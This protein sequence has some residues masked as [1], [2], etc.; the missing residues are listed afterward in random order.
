VRAYFEGGPDNP[1][2]PVLFEQTVYGEAAPSAA[3]LNLCGRLWQQ[4]DGAGRAVND[5]YDFKGNV[6][7]SSRRL[8]TEYRTTPDW[9]V[10]PTGKLEAEEFTSRSWFDALN[11]PIQVVP[12]HS[13]QTTTSVLRPIYNVAG[14][15]DSEYAWLERAAEPGEG[16]LL[17][18][19]TAT[20]RPIV[21]VVY[22]ARGQR[23]SISYGN[24]V[25][26]RYAYDDRTFRLLGLRTTRPGGRNGMS[27]SLFRDATVVQD[28]SYVYDAAGNITRIEDAALREIIFGGQVVRPV[29]EYTYDALYRLIEATGREHIAQ[30]TYDPLRQN[31][32]DYPFIGPGPAVTDP[33]AFRTYTERYLY[34]DVGNIT[35]LQHRAAGGDWTR[36]YR[37]AAGSNRL[38]STS[39]PGDPD[40]GPY[41]ATYGHNAHGDLV[42]AWNLERLDWDLKGQ[43]SA[44]AVQR[45]TIGGT[46]PETTYYAYDASGRRFR[47]ITEP[48]T[49]GGAAAS[50]LY[51]RI[52]VGDFELYR[53]Y[54]AGGDVEREFLRLGDDRQTVAIV[55]TP[56]RQLPSPNPSPRVFRYQIADHLGS[57]G[58][59][60]DE[61]AALISHEEY[62]PYGTTAYRS[63][64]ASHEVQARRYR[65]SGLERDE[66]T[67]L[68]Y[69]GARY[70]SPW[71]GRWISCDP[72]A[73]V[74]DSNLYAYV[75]AN[76][77]VYVDPTGTQH[78]VAQQ[79]RPAVPTKAQAQAWLAKQDPDAGLTPEAREAR[80]FWAG[81]RIVNAI[82]DAIETGVRGI[83][84]GLRWSL[85][86]VDPTGLVEARIDQVDR[87]VGWGDTGQGETGRAL[88]GALGLVAGPEKVLT[89]AESKAASGLRAM[90]GGGELGK[91]VTRMTA[92]EEALRAAASTEATVKAGSEVKA[93]FGD[94][95]AGTEVKAATTEATEVKAAKKE[96]LTDVAAPV[97]SEK[98][99]KSLEVELGRRELESG[100]EDLTGGH[101]TVIIDE[102]L[103]K[104]VKGADDLALVASKEG[105]VPAK[106][107]RKVLEKTPGGVRA[108]GDELNSTL[109]ELKKA[110]NERTAEV[111][112]KTAAERAEARREARATGG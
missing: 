48:L 91:T 78:N 18:P 65:Y 17:D 72:A 26:T 83:A 47:K 58:V 96:E 16:E 13:S 11:R 25:V 15:L 34:D 30:C 49:I 101:H 1:A 107:L 70:C 105:R 56:T 20:F 77:I 14:L 80:A 61:H 108:L 44:S 7:R 103:E 95:K 60:L 40:A 33:N 98:T 10:D 112:D 75:H 24:G 41:S 19:A 51:E 110:H 89:A 45:T 92:S 111:L 102:L 32:R 62:H 109:K 29:S 35:S 104:G 38:D 8:A 63:A 88:R 3:Q 93:A 54:G 5:E 36:R 55:E 39:L 106:D 85:G 87:D 68:T 74:A 59:A 81:N 90:E 73:L 79:T 67:G 82:G 86:V 42:R 12:P 2:A 22:N 37:Y 28:L 84:V 31:P 94:M 76:P 50:P 43:L 4:Y 71:L 53:A 69:H 99:R 97:K 46:T 21:D 100:L 52:Y 66:E 9:R 64:D 27:T 57:I 6:V 23:E